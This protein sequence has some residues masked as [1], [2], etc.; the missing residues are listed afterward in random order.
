MGRMDGS[1]RA[2]ISLI[3]LQEVS[4]KIAVGIIRLPTAWKFEIGKL[5]IPITT[6][7]ATT[8]EAATRTTTTAAA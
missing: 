2:L 6:T 3:G 5:H 1:S 7:A 4:K 8:A